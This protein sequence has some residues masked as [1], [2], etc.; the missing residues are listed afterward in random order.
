M[1]QIWIS[2][3]LIF[4]N[5]VDPDIGMHHK[6]NIMLLAILPRIEI[7][8]ILLFLI[9]LLVIS[10][11]VL[12]R[13]EFN[14]LLPIFSQIPFNILH[15]TVWFYLQILCIRAFCFIIEFHLLPTHPI[16]LCNS[17]PISEFQNEFDCSLLENQFSL[18]K[19]GLP[20]DYWFIYN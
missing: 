19:W 18:L 11:L 20:I 14:F 5:N 8:S 12:A 4:L 10:F 17:F 13:V 15:K 3:L 9:I 2:F 1:E 16:H 6:L 7:Y